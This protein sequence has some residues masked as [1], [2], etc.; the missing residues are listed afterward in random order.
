MKL[1][2]FNPILLLKLSSAND[3]I[4]IDKKKYVWRST[5]LGWID[6]WSK[7][8]SSHWMDGEMEE[9]KLLYI[10]TNPSNGAL[11]TRGPH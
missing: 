10:A 5:L 11:F 8:R 4:S 7:K 6:G 2:Q 3:Q 9:E 1:L